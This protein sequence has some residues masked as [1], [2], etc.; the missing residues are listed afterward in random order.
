MGFKIIPIFANILIL[1]FAVHTPVPEANRRGVEMNRD[2]TNS[3][4]YGFEMGLLKVS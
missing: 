2:F 1:V 4:Q 3:L